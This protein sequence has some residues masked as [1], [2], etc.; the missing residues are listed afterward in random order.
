M[1]LHLFSMSDMHNPLL[2]VSNPRQQLVEQLEYPI[3]AQLDPVYTSDDLSC[4]FS[5]YVEPGLVNYY[6]EYLFLE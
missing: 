3:G 2:Y 5:T 4:S 1:G 6:S